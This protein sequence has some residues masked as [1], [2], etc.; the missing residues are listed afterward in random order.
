MFVCLCVSF[1]FVRLFVCLCVLLVETEREREREIDLKLCVLALLL[2]STLSCL[3]VYIYVQS[4]GIPKDVTF[5]RLDLKF[6]K[7]IAI[8]CFLF[9]VFRSCS[10]KGS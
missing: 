6:S 8:N 9:R 1:V 4:I 5:E 7:K 10:S 2:Y 3:S